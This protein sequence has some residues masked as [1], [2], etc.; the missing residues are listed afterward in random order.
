MR[1]RE[2]G[3]KTQ[4]KDGRETAQSFRRWHLC[5]K[6]K[7]RVVTLEV[8]EEELPLKLVARLKTEPLPKRARS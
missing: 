5:P 1:C 4:I 8:P 2:C 7:R 6:C 3:H